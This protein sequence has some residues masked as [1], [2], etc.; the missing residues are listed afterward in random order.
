MANWTMR[1]GHIIGGSAVLIGVLCNWAGGATIAI[2]AV[3]ALLTW[4]A[5][6]ESDLAGYKVYQGTVSGQYGPPVTLGLVTSYTLTLPSLA[7]DQRY[8]WAITAYDLTGNESS[9][10]AEVSKLV[11][12]DPA[13]TIPLAPT[14]LKVSKWDGSQWV[15]LASA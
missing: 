9:K 8:F 14:G 10:S 2:S 3:E 7:I 11:A 13:Q 4:N 12:G 5:N 6:T 1:R 15:L